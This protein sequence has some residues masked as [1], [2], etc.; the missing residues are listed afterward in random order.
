MATVLCH[1]YNEEYL[2]PW[3]LKHHKQ[4][5]D[6]GI[7]VDYAST[8]RSVEI[9]R[10]I[11]PTWEIRQSK[12]ENFQMDKINEEIEEIERQIEGWRI[13]LNVP[14]FLLGDLSIT[15]SY[16]EETTS[17][18]NYGLPCKEVKFGYG[19]PVIT[20]VDN[21]P[22]IIPSY[23]VPLVEQKNYGIH[24]NEGSF[25]IRNARLLHKNKDIVYGVGRHYNYT[26]ED[27]VILWYGWSPYNER[28]LN[29]KM[30]IKD[31]IPKS[32]RDK[33]FGHQH[34]LSREQMDDTHSNYLKKSRNLKQDLKKYYNFKKNITKKLSILINVKLTDDRNL[35]SYYRHPWVKR[36]DRGDV[37]KYAL[38]SYS[39][40]D[41]F[42]EKYHLFIE[43][44]GQYV[45]RKKEFEEFIFSIFPKEKI[46]LCW[47]RHTNRNQWKYFCDSEVDDDEVILLL[48]ND[49]HVFIDYNTDMIENSINVLN[50]DQDPHSAVY[51]S[52]WPEQMVLSF[53]KNAELTKDKNF[54]KFKWNNFDSIQMMKGARLKKYWEN[55]WNSNA[56][57]R[58]DSLAEFGFELES[59]FY[60]PTR[61]IFRHYDGYSHVGNIENFCPPL[62]IPEGF[63]EKQMKLKFGFKQYDQKCVNINATSPT[64]FSADMHSSSDYRWVKEDIPLFWKNKIVSM[65]FSGDYD[66]SEQKKYRNE[67]F[68]LCTKLKL[69]KLKLYNLCYS[70]DYLPHIHNRPLDNFSNHIR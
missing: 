52:H 50:E 35:S 56:L 65:E 69:D 8:D 68:F 43:L 47:Y 39:S 45:E 13:C 28:L 5:F 60:S 51:I 41:S 29:R 2:L 42:V 46:N 3:W 19:I 53:Y 23:D 14:E 21:K 40:F 6:H 67:Y 24:Y 64:I 54:F 62:Y 16:S 12:N 59:D 10:E 11:C 70:S 57:Y 38:A 17:F 25:E 1:F 18:V 26:T 7:M 33:G 66:E 32:D 31:R 20:M 61:E 15:D 30:Q 58:T 37:F 49:D 63:F 34:L 4:M 44:E 48:C 9:I 27:L 22:E 55:D 36:D